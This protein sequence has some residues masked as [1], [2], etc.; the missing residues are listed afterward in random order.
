MRLTR[1]V[2]LTI[3]VLTVLV[4]MGL[5]I[6]GRGHDGPAALIPA[7]QTQVTAR[8]TQSASE[9][10]AQTQARRAATVSA[11]ETQVARLHAPGTPP[12]RSPAPATPLAEGTRGSGARSDWQAV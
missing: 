10:T 1:V 12:A 3:A 2:W 9:A 11:L 5:V 7:V 6:A 4:L 8:Q